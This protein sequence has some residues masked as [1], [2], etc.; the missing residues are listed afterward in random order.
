MLYRLTLEG[1]S[2]LFLQLS[3]RP[4]GKVDAVIPNTPEA[5]TKVERINHQVAAW[6]INYWKDTNPGRNSFFWKLAS[7]AFCQ[8]LLH[9]VGNC[10]WDLTT[11][12]VTS[13]HAQ[14][15]MAAVAAFENQ[16]WVQD[17]LQ[18]TSNSTKE[19][20]YINP[21]VAFPFQDD[22][23]VGT[24]P[25]ANAGTNK[26]TPQHAASDKSNKE[27]VFKILDNDDDNDMSVLTS[28]TQDKLVALLVQARKQ[29]S[30]ATVGSRVAFSSNLPHESGPAAML[31]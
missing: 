18:V 11:Q 29:L 16:V 28:K 15:E 5:K 25:G 6:C 4:L 2:P 20:A 8:V 24:I 7:K 12:T 27:G 9:E 19:K 14:L 23:S 30:G 17:I 13:P 21:N 1:G 22:F 3:Q 10:T 26:C 31:S